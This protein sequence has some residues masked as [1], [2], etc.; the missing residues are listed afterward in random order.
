MKKEFQNT[1]PDER[2]VIEQIKSKY[3]E[4]PIF[5]KKYADALKSVE[6]HGIIS[7]TIEK[8]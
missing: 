2:N 1:Q 8:T 5:S 3:G 7:K 4:K 6:K